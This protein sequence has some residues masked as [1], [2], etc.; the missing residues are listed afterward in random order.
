MAQETTITHKNKWFYSLWNHCFWEQTMF[1]RPIK[2]LFIAKNSWFET[3]NPLYL[4]RNI[5]FLTFKKLCLLTI[6]IVFN[7]CNHLIIKKRWFRQIINQWTP[8]TICNYRLNGPHFVSFRRT[9]VN[10]NGL[11][12]LKC[13]DFR[14]LFTTQCTIKSDEVGTIHQKETGWNDEMVYTRPGDQS[15]T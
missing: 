4:S 5:G 2:P 13:I 6:S 12:P 7:L 15:H 3:G 11:R 1:L 8:T 9:T 10:F 14:S